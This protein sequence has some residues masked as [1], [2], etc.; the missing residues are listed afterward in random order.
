MSRSIRGL[1]GAPL[2]MGVIGCATT[3]EFDALTQKVTALQQQQ[4]ATA[5]QVETFNRELQQAWAMLF[6]G[7]EMAQL[8]DDVRREC[9]GDP[10]EPLPAGG[11]CSAESIAPAVIDADPAH[12]GMFLSVVSKAPHEAF[13]VAA[14]ADLTDFRQRRLDLLLQKRLRAT[15]ILVVARMNPK[16]KDQKH[17]AIERAQVL[18]TRLL[19]LGIDKREI[20][21]WTYSFPMTKQEQAQ[22]LSQIHSAEPHD[23]NNG[24]WVFLVNC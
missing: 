4:A 14:G 16:D 18:I 23:L 24:V 10:V 21:R 20:R 6:C 22:Y 11:S 13:P 7:S 17:A 5:Q 15:R 1:A 8:I 3:G 19:T 2:L 9:A 12:R